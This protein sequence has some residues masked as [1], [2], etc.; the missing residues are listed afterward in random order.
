MPVVHTG[1]TTI[2]YEDRGEGEP[3]VL[4]MGTAASGRVWHLHQVPALVEAG[5]RVITFDNR[6]V[7]PASA[8]GAEEA[9]D[10][11]FTIDDLVED[12]AGLIGGLGL[13]PCRVVGTSMGAQV[14]TELALKHPELVSQAVLMA[15]RGRPDAMRRAWGVAERELRA[16]SVK[17]PARYE[18]VQR[19]VWNLSPSTL[20]DDAAV[21]DWLDLFEMSP[22]MWTPELRAQLDLDI[23]DSRLDAYRAIRT[24]CLVL[25][26]ADDLRLPP[27]LAREVAEAIPG[28]V[29]REI[30]HCG[31]YGYLERP[32]EVNAAMVTF[33]AGGLI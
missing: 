20:N 9:G 17:L 25:G 30:A 26:F 3:V 8:L 14:V 16:T 19:A 15:T 32:D 7:A 21:T 27:Y 2:A 28:A 5:Y 4:V 12:T 6:G 10:P 22:I 29:F 23:V 1:G 18:A 11:R 13:G 24:P 31:H 33:F